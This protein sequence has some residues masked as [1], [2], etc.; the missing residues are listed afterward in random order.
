MSVNLKLIPAPAIRPRPPAWWGWLLLLIVM[1]LGGMADAI[2]SNMSRKETNAEEFWTSALG[3]PALLWLILLA[4]RITWY[5]GQLAT[6]HSKDQERDRQLRREMQRGQR[7]L[8]VFAMSLH[9]AL[10]EPEDADGSKQ[11]D[12]LQGKVKG[13]KTQ[14][15][16]Q[17]HEG[18]RHSRLVQVNGESAEQMLSRGLKKTLEELSPVLSSLPDETPLALLLESN[19]S[20][21][22]HL[23]EKTWHDSW[24]ASQIR[25]TVMR[26]EGGGLAAIDKWLDD[27]RNEHSLLMVISSQINPKNPEGSAESIVGLLLGGGTVSPELVPHARLHRPEMVHHNGSDDFEYA[28]KQSMEWVP[29]AADEV[30]NGFLVG[31]KPTWHMTIATGLQAIQ[32]PI[33]AGQDLHDLGYTL[34]F[35]GPVAP[36]VAITCAVRACQFSDSQLIVSGNNRDN[37]Q[38]WVTLVTS[39]EKQYE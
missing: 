28:L 13:L 34:G 37:T 32:S 12:L 9:S 38:L 11:W 26:I 14:P 6:V 30:K 17:S 36:W 27:L 23:V 22:E 1:L 35:P 19:S 2:L 29:I 5:K 15:S 31:V 7:Y 3:L 24:A 25:Q 39:A 8:N 16:W 20:L 33:N 18:I 4:L 10:R 21:P